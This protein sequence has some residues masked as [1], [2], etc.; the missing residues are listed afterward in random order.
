M[1]TSILTGAG[2]CLLTLTAV[3]L[4]TAAR[5][6]SPETPPPKL[7]VLTT[8]HLIEGDIRLKGG[9]YWVKSGPGEFLVPND[10]IKLVAADR[11]EAYRKYRKLMPEP[12]P[13]NHYYLARWCVSIGL[14][15]EARQ[16]LEEALLLD[17]RHAGSRSL[18]VQL[19]R[20]AGEMPQADPS[21]EI[22]AADRDGDGFRRTEERSAYGLTPE[23]VRTY[24]SRIQPVLMNSCATVGCHHRNAENGL[25]LKYVRLSGRINRLATESNLAAVL[26]MIDRANPSASPLLQRARDDHP[27]AYRALARR[28]RGTEILARFDDWVREV[29]A[30][31]NSLDEPPS[32]IGAAASATSIRPA[33][34]EKDAETSPNNDA[35]STSGARESNQLVREILRNSRPDP[36]NPAAFNR[37]RE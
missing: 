1:R 14:A 23:T 34:G 5:G 12:T 25:Q 6:Q 30:D 33:T 22:S 36:F 3:G 9:A 21:E 11:T 7:I 35:P 24:V 13:D 37:G 10:R 18:L 17:P 31:L 32:G 19:T 2:I 16:E 29:A 28:R 26:K 4:R 20:A 27:G 15:D 8:G